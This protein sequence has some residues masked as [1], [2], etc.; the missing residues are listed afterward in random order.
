M[1][2]SGKI[3][4]ISC[5][6]LHNTARRS[7]S[8]LFSHRRMASTKLLVLA[9][10][11][12]FAR[13]SGQPKPKCEG[14]GVITRKDVRDMSSAEWSNYATAFK[15][16]MSKN[17]GRT[18][19][20]IALNLMEALSQDH[21]TQGKKDPEV[22]HHTPLFVVWH[23]LMLWELDKKLHSV[24]RGT[25]QPYF[26]WSASSSNLF[27]S[28]VFSSSRYGGSGKPIPNGAFAKIKSAVGIPGPRHFVRRSFD[29]SVQLESQTFMNG[30]VATEGFTKFRRALEAAHDAF[31]VAIGGDMVVRFPNTRS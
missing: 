21:L 6:C 24:R 30:L 13:A 17:S 8:M 31:H 19:G 12:V 20:G 28:A 15:G 3:V 26:D 9:L 7:H 2:C 4:R 14:L 5:R 1:H 11:C 29:S 16:L 10:L 22:I 23:R 25:R 27:G 18:L